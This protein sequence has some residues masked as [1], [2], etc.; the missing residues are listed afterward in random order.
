MRAL[1]AFY[2]Y[3]TYSTIQLHTEYSHTAYTLYIL[4]HHPSALATADSRPR[5]LE[6]ANQATCFAPV[7]PSQDPIALL[8]DSTPHGHYGHQAE[9]ARLASF[10][11]SCHPAPTR[12]QAQH[13]PNSPRCPQRNLDGRLGVKSK[14][15]PHTHTLFHMRRINITFALFC[16]HGACRSCPHWQNRPV[17]WC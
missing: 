4:I 14:K 8:L 15:Q 16:R 11:P 2:R 10:L 13:E 17:L 9:Q 6:R 12:S 3:S 1:T 5:R 7:A